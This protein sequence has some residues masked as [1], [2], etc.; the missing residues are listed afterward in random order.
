LADIQS[1]AIFFLDAILGPGFSDTGA[2]LLVTDGGAVETVNSIGGTL[3]TLSARNTASFRPTWSRSHPQANNRPAWDF[4]TN[5]RMRWDG[6]DILTGEFVLQWVGFGKADNW[7]P[8]NQ[9]LR[10]INLATENPSG[11][12]QY[13]G[14]SDPAR[15]YVNGVGQWNMPGGA[16]NVSPAVFTVV[17]AAGA[18]TAYMNGVQLSTIVTDGYVSRS[19]DRLVLHAATDLGDPADGWAGNPAKGMV[20]QSLSLWPGSLATTVVARQVALMNYWGIVG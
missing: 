12:E 4:G 14:C 19:I 3:R 20:L 17:Y 8:A 15:L 13:W 6:I 5:N 10:F 16:Q 9:F 11:I 18:R 2:S 1:S 7:I